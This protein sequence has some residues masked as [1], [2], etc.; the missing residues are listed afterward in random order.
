MFQFLGFLVE[1]HN[2]LDANEIKRLMTE[3]SKDV[4]HG[5]CFVCCVMSHGDQY[6]IFGIDKKSCTLKDIRSP[7]D[8]VNCPSLVNKPK[9]F[10]IQACRGG[11]LQKKVL[12]KT[13]ASGGEPD[14]ESDH[15]TDDYTIASGS[16]FL[17]VMSTVEGCV[18]LRNRYSGTL[19]IQSL[20][21]Y[22]KDGSQ[23]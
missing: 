10:I 21:K 23:R 20:C 7:F 19:F 11:E 13:D 9:V 1:E 18:S 17:T 6:G 12:V 15:V 3:Y 22:L 8:G 16:D 5:D 14:L 2:D 4:R